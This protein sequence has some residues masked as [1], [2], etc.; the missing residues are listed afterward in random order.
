MSTGILI[1]NYN[2]AVDTIHCIDSIEQHNTAPVKYIIV[3]NGS[4]LKDTVPTLDQFF[5]ERFKEDYCQCTASGL[6][7][8][9]L[10]KVT[11]VLNPENSGYAVGNNLA[12]AQASRDSEITDILLLNNDTLFIEDIIPVLKEDSISLDSCGFVTPLLLYKDGKRVDNCCARKFIG[13]WNLM[14]PFLLHQR[15]YR[16]WISKCYWKQGIIALHPELLNKNQPFP[17]DY[18]SGSCLYISKRAFQDLG[19]FDPDTFLYYEELILFKKMLVAGY[20]NY[21]DPRIRIIHLGGSS[22]QMSDNS[23]L[24]RCNLESAD[25]YF[26][27]YGNC[28]PL[29]RIVWSLTKLSWKLRLGLKDLM[30]RK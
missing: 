12:L 8:G 26:R 7:E 3:D 21:C 18:P 30:K 24:Q 16:K 27:K 15:N 28:S 20:Q 14:V 29:Q 6:I 17:I 22:T 5:K 4:S 11:F 23:F 25:V 10:P 19:G 13:N 2:N 1:L 9:V